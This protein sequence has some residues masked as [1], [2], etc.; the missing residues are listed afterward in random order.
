MAQSVHLIDVLD[1][2]RSAQAEHGGT[3]GSPIL[4]VDPLRQSATYFLYAAQCSI[5]AKM[6][7]MF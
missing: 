6:K 1:E 4:P 2:R 7:R 5:E 3:I